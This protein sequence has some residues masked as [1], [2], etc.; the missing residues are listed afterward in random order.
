MVKLSFFCDFF[1]LSV[2]LSFLHSFFL[3]FFPASFVLVRVYLV[4]CCYLAVHRFLRLETPNP[5]SIPPIPHATSRIHPRWL[6]ATFSLDFHSLLLPSPILQPIQTLA[7]FT[8]FQSLTP[9]QSSG[10]SG[11][12]PER[13]VNLRIMAYVSPFPYCCICLSSHPRSPII[14]FLR[15]PLLHLVIFS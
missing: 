15:H 14:S 1:L 4:S 12:M 2:F 11:P 9:L 3:T 7:I 13:L 5:R 8:I 10:M 6:H